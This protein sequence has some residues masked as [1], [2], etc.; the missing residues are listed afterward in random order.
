MMEDRRFS[1]AAIVTRECFLGN[2]TEC[3]TLFAAKP[4]AKLV[5]DEETALNDYLPW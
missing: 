5:V 1:A 2:Q 3:A 4:L